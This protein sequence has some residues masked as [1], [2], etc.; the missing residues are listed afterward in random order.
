MM[1]P[2]DILRFSTRSLTGFRTRTI[3]M[4]IAMAIG[5]GSGRDLKTAREGGPGDGSS[6]IY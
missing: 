2:G 6:R 3:L 1:H 4:V 5:V